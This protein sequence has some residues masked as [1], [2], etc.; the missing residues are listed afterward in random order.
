MR[1]VVQTEERLLVQ[2][3]ECASEH[4]Q[5]YA[6]TRALGG[7]STL[8]LATTGGRNFVG[9]R[10]DRAGHSSTGVRAWHSW[11]RSSKESMSLK[12]SLQR[13]V[14]SG[15]PSSASRVSK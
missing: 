7:A 8:G 4:L 6:P 11:G 5:P 13:S 3:E 14:I 2:T 10:Q 15:L 12:T 9:A 1:V